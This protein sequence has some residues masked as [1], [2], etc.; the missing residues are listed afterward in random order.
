MQPRSQG[1]LLRRAGRREPW[2][3]GCSSC[4]LQCHRVQFVLR[5][6][7][8]WRFKNLDEKRLHC[9]C[10]YYITW[11]VET[12]RLVYDLVQF[13]KG[14]RFEAYHIYD[15]RSKRTNHK[16]GCFSE[17]RQSNIFIPSQIPFIWKCVFL[18]L[19]FFFQKVEGPCPKKPPASPPARV[20]RWG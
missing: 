2:E 4:C 5:N 10:I 7:T 15:I 20:L 14:S 8:P 19:I 17:V 18:N 13:C 3:R 12:L 11:L 1:S 9:L 6:R 16:F